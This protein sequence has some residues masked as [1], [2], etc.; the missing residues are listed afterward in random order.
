M[1]RRLGRRPRPLEGP[2]GPRVLGHPRSLV[3]DRRDFDQNDRQ[4][5]KIFL[6][7]PGAG[8][9]SHIHVVELL[10]AR[11]AV[12][13]IERARSAGQTANRGHKGRRRIPPSSAPHRLPRTSQFLSHTGHRRP[14]V[15]IRR[16]ATRCGLR[17]RLRQAVSHRG[18]CI[19]R[20]VCPMSDRSVRCKATGT[21]CVARRSSIACSLRS[22]RAG[23]APASG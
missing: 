9:E 2:D 4:F 19:R 10:A 5:Y 14:F 21:A 13:G 8:L 6:T 17:F 7:A 3:H 12:F 1:V 15:E 23:S 16:G 18:W 20:G 22:S 11:T